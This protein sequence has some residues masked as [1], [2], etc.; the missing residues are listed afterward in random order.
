[1]K[2]YIITIFLS[3]MFNYT[4]SQKNWDGEYPWVSRDQ[5]GDIRKGISFTSFSSETYVLGK[6]KSVKNIESN[7]DTILF[8]ESNRVSHYFD[9]ENKK[10]TIIRYNYKT[11]E[12]YDILKIRK[13]INNKKTEGI[14]KVILKKGK[15]KIGYY[16]DTY[17]QYYYKY[18]YSKKY[19][20]GAIIK[21]NINGTYYKFDY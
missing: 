18:T 13:K 8:V 6:T 21:N 19:E 16:I 7:I 9:L 14:I 10:L 2:K 11:Y 20:V 17:N 5:Y 12:E 3:T 15:T 4:Y 1:M